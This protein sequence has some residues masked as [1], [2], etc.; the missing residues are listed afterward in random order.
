MFTILDPETTVWG[1]DQQWVWAILT[2]HLCVC[3]C[4]CA[5][6]CV[7]VCVCVR[8]RVYVCVCVCVCA[9]ARIN[10]YDSSSLYELK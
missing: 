5:C 3:V 10:Y 8:V 1:L 7:C 6:V 2:D 4:V 9:H